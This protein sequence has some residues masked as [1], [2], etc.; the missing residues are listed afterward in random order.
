MAPCTYFFI[1]LHFLNFNRH[2]RKKVFL[3]I[4]WRKL[5]ILSLDCTF[6]KSAYPLII[7]VIHEISLRM[8]SLQS[9]CPFMDGQFISYKD[10][11]IRKKLIRFFQC[12]QSGFAFF[13]PWTKW[14]GFNRNN[15]ALTWNFSENNTYGICICTE[16]HRSNVELD[17]QL[18]RVSSAPA[19]VFP[20]YYIEINCLN[21]YL[22][23]TY[24]NNYYY[25]DMFTIIINNNII[26]IIIVIRSY[27]IKIKALFLI[28][29]SNWTE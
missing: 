16:I 12:Q 10:D 15:V 27:E 6:S 26:I 1:F 8:S 25:C 29:N 4:V 17:L 24:H 9:F 3:C 22:I 5:I 11:Q 14:P 23:W 28:S 18:P 2:K 7:F 13:F 19:Q 20:L 21:F